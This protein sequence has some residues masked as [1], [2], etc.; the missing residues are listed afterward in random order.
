MNCGLRTIQLAYVK[1]FLTDL[2]NVLA[3][4]RSSA[5][6]PLGIRVCK[7]EY[8]L[9]GHWAVHSP[10]NLR[11]LTRLRRYL[12]SF[13]ILLFVKYVKVVFFGLIAY[14]FLVRV[15]SFLLLVIAAIWVFSFISLLVAFTFVLLFLLSTDDSFEVVKSYHYDGYVVKGLPV[16]TIFKYALYA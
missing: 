9:T 16:K 2:T 10:L 11:C 3:A 1:I 7:R 15:G 8:L 14:F 6:V 4:Y 5:W 12:L 13:D